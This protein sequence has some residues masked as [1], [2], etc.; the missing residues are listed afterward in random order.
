MYMDEFPIHD[1]DPIEAFPALAEIPDPPKVLHM[2][3]SLERTIGTKLIT[4]VGSRSYTCIKC[5]TVCDRV[6]AKRKT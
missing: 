4:V 6:D 1:I 5:G 3:G 2:R